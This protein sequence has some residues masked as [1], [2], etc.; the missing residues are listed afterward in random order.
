M[1]FAVIISEKGG[2]ERREVFDK[3]EIS[4]GRVQGNDL[5]LPKGNVSKRH[6]RIVFRDGRFIVTDLKSTNGSY[7]NG[8][9]IAQATIVREGDKIY[10]G[11]FILRLDASNSAQS[12]LPSPRSDSS[13]PE[14]E[15]MRDMDGS[16][17]TPAPRPMSNEPSAVSHIPLEHD[18]DDPS[19][20]GLPV[21]GGL[22]SRPPPARPAAVANQ[23]VGIVDRPSFGRGSVGGGPTGNI[24]PPTPSAAPPPP[25][26]PPARPALVPLA[27]QSPAA[28]GAARPAPAR[29][30][31][32]VARPGHFNALQSLLTRLAD[33]VDLDDADYATISDA[34]RASIERVL[35]EQARALQ[36]EGEI[37]G[38]VSADELVREAVREA[39]G[40]GPLGELID[41]EDVTE[42]Q[43]ARFDHIV[44]IRDGAGATPLE[45][46]FTSEG[47]FRR[48]LL[49]L[50]A[51][52]GFKLRDADKT[53]DVRLPS[54]VHLTAILPPV[55]AGGTVASLRK[56]RRADLG[57]EDL[58]R[59]GTISRSMATF[60]QQC[61]A[62]KANVLV[63]GPL[64][65]GTTT[66]IGALG[67]AVASDERTIAI[68]E[69]DEIVLTQPFGSSLI[70]PDTSA[71]GAR[72]V[73]LAGSLR[74]DRLLVGVMGGD[75][76]G[77]VVEAIGGGLDGVV[78]AVRGPTLRQ[79]LARLAPALVASRPGLDPASARAWIASSF[80]VAVEVARLKGGRH[81]V[82]RI[83][84]LAGADATEI[85]TRDVF[86]FVLDP[87][88]ADRG[89]GAFQ[90]TG[91][92]PAVV[93]ELKGL[94]HRV[95]ETIFRRGTR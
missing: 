94:G 18:P 42:V 46:A 29:K 65:A 17:P 53:I 30:E 60:L 14:A 3:N 92:I 57:L 89:E 36:Q 83:A 40:T 22:P 35:K 1:S 80:D 11:D 73:R 82:L 4:I 51:T 79:A 24:V 2:Q 7:V 20:A 59:S 27:S 15:M 95:D 38:G 74:P 66:L 77:Q 13:R 85:K 63:A 33:V 76:V 12:P 9:R 8:H 5:L 28:A 91:V 32:T 10:I 45:I 62:A 55:A 19:N 48:A 52:A 84:E 81:R 23:V 58:V 68:Q 34:K 37:P 21:V 16:V 88:Q 26:A 39:V 78:A 93:Q 64:G 75:V 87:A 69:I 67:A 71:E 49:R 56:R 90:A 70:V 6:A 72:I 54:G 61:L 50:A 25:P 31:P 43:A 86:E 44:V 47:T 41:D